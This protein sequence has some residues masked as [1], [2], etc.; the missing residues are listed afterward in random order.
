MKIIL[1]ALTILSTSVQAEVL[2]GNY[3]LKKSKVDYLVTYLIK[4]APAESV[5]S[6]GKGECKDAAC[7]FLIAA[8]VKSFV[9]KDSNR[10]LNMLGVVKGD[11]F[12]LVAVHVKSKSDISSGKLI[13]DL[14]VDFAGIKL[15]YPGVVFTATKTADGFH[16]AGKFDLLLLKHKIERPTLLGV[17]IDENVPMTIEADWKK[18]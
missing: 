11:K 4:K 17:A 10:D 18:I 16:V 13:A 6:K 5:E 3:E 15:N 9:S 1:I 12:P 8:P 14:E 7:E 2:S